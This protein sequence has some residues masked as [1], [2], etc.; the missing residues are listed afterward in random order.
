MNKAKSIG[1]TFLI[2]LVSFIVCYFLQKVYNIDDSTTIIFVFAVFLVSLYT[3]GYLYGI[4]AAFV[5][6]IAVNF[7]FKVPFF[8]FNFM[9]PGN[10]ISSIIMIIISI[11]TSTFT[12]RIKYWESLKAEGERER[13]RANLLRA[14]SHDF[15]TPLTTIYGSSSA[16]LENR[17]NLSESQ[18]VKMLQGIKEEA[19][20]LTRMVENML[21]ITRIDSGKVKIIKSPTVLEELVD[22]AVVKFKKSFPQQPVDIEIPE[23]I[24][25][26]PMDAILIE[27]VIINLLENA[28][29]HAKGM[30]SL[31]LKVTNLEKMVIFE[32]A[33]NG[34]G[35]DEKKMK[36]IFDQY[37]TS[38]HETNDSQKKNVGIGL[39]VCKTIIKAH[40]GEIWVENLKT[41]GAVF[42]FSLNKEVSSNE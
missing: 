9:L 42:R 26:I 1:I 16:L 15:R 17:D 40:D 35:I 11:L 21:S 23:D 30:T 29:Y 14:V 8:A 5:A 37:Y 28:V 19:E 41:G 39:S 34:C 32:I 4:V 31:A 25:I 12:T 27:Q 24:V 38:A 36:N 7:A 20:W 10:L 18:K 13:T 33:D 3:E 22:T 2:M 6:T